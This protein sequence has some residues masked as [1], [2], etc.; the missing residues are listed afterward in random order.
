M[1]RLSTRVM[2]R[3]TTARRKNE[4]LREKTVGR[5]SG[6]EREMGYAADGVREGYAQE[7]WRPARVP[8][9]FTRV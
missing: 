4:E 1:E 7:G 6:R 3:F 8:G 2:F 5:E 9:L